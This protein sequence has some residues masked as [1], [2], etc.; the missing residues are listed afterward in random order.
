MY[1]MNITDI[2]DK[3]IVS[4]RKEHLFNQFISKFDKVNDELLA[5]TTDAWGYYVQTKLGKYMA[6]L[7]MNEFWD[8]V[9]SGSL[10]GD[11]DD[12]KF[13]LHVKTA[14]NANNALKSFNS[15]KVTKESE[16]EQLL[17]FI[18]VTRDILS[19]HLDFLHGSTITDPKIFQKFAT[20]WEKEFFKEMDS[21]GVLRPDVVT[22]VSE[23]VDE[24][25]DYVQTIIKNGYA[26]ES[27]GNT[28]F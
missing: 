21:L 22:R 15:S 25:K 4:A 2:D 17:Q 5:S 28:N 14:Q 26:Y 23:Y 20:Y 19:T 1:V 7:E 27:E 18:L 6:G 12:L 13:G 3:I 10:K 11:E 16:S 8:K 9:H 24:I